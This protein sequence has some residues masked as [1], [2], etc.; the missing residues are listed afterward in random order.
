M[1]PVPMWNMGGVPK[2]SET[3][4]AFSSALPKIYSRYPLDSLH[5]RLRSLWESEYDQHRSTHPHIRLRWVNHVIQ[6]DDNRIPQQRT[7]YG[8]LSIGSRSQHKPRKRFKDC[9][10]DKLALCKTDD[11]NW[12]MVVCG[13]NRWRKMVHGGSRCFQDNANIWTKTKRAARKGDN[14]DPDL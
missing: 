2:T 14:I 7:K 10:K 4:R 11:P 5:S 6:L 3:P 8:E 13:R 12:E 9:V 1:P